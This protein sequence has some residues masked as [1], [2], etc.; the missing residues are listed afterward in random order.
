[1]PTTDSQTFDRRDPHDILGVPRGADR[2]QVMRAFR[3]KARQGSHPDTG[4]DTQSFE[5]IIRARQ[6]LLD[7]ARP[8]TN[9]TSRRT[10]T[11]ARPPKTH[12][13]PANHPPDISPPAETSKLAVAGAVLALLGPLFWPVAIM[14][15][16]LALRHIQRTGKGGARFARATLFVL[17]PLTLY[18][19]AF[20]LT[21][22]VNPQ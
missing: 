15:G 10:A 2:Q 16:H 1:M 14:V 12:P 20:I 17:Y 13:S 21:V 9:P 4:G 19:L 6:A 5:E 11:E 22:I 3:R 18:A 7:P 8:A